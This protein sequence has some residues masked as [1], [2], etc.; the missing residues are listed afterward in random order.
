MCGGLNR[1]GP[2]R[3]MCLNAWAI[4]SSTI[5]RHGPVGKCGLGGEN[6]QLQRQPLRSH[7]CSS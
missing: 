7:I 5:R 1:D 4:G 3:L 6:V 2:H